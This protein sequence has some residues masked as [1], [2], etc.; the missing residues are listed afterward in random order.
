ML[1]FVGTAR[2]QGRCR[3][4]KTPTLFSERTRAAGHF[5][6]DALPLLQQGSADISHT[7]AKAVSTSTSMGIRIFEMA[8]ASERLAVVEQVIEKMRDAEAMR[9]KWA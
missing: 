2:A 6:S 1:A 5:S 4:A 7:S 3:K 8:E 9:S